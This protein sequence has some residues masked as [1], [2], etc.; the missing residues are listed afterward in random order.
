MVRARLKTIHGDFIRMCILH[1]IPRPRDIF[2]DKIVVKVNHYLYGKY[3]TAD[4]FLRE[5]YEN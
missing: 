3:H 4:I 1:E 2:D 5:K